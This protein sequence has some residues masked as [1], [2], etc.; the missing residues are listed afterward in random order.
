MYMYIIHIKYPGS[1][2]ITSM[3]HKP[4]RKDHCFEVFQAFVNKQQFQGMIFR[5]LDFQGI[6]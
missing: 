2:K 6:Y 1:P 4:A 3:V 5:M